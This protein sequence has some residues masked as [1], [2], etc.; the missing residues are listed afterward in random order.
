MWFNWRTEDGRWLEG[1][2]T[3]DMSGNVLFVLTDAAPA[4]GASIVV[5][6]V[7]HALKM[8]QRPVAFY[9]YGKVVRIELVSG[10]F[11]IRCSLTFEERNYY[12]CRD[13]VPRQVGVPSRQVRSAIAA[14]DNLKPDGN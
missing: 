12:C 5:I 14:T 10:A 8:L 2:G 6:V 3:K 4:A 11:W 1:E 13:E 9:G 7:M